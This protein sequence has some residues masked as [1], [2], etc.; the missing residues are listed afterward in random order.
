M[1]RSLFTFSCHDKTELKIYKAHNV[2]WLKGRFIQSSD[3]LLRSKRV[4]LLDP[5]LALP[6]IDESRMIRKELSTV[7]CW[8]SVCSVLKLVTG[9]A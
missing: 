9:F 3:P 6:C 1:S 4:N 7:W 8:V 2:D 5:L